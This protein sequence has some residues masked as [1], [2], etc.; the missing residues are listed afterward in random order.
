MKLNGY[1]FTWDKGAGA[2]NHIEVLLDRALVNPAFL[3]IFKEA[4]LT[5]L[6]VSTSDHCPI[7]MEPVTSTTV[8]RSKV[9]RFENAWLR[10]PMCYQI[11]E[12]VW[13]SNN[14]TMYEKLSM[15][16][17]MLSAWGKEITGNFKGRI[18]RSKQILKALK[19]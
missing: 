5:N 6:E 9:F 14:G 18:H 19:G 2:Y 10:E 16:A 15:C 3:S 13:S 1:Q 8:I 7:L 12:D 11:V 17:E 4:K